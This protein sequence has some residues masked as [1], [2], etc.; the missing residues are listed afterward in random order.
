MRNSPGSVSR[1]IKL[2]RGGDSVA[3]TQVWNRYCKRLLAIAR[4]RLRGAGQT[5]SDEEDVVVD[6]FHSV[7]RRLHC[8]QYPKL[9]DRDGLWKLLA[10]ATTNKAITQLRFQNR[11]KRTPKFGWDDQ[12]GQL[13][14]VASR[15]DSAHDAVETADL[16]DHLLAVLPDD[17][18]RRI[19]LLRLNG[20]GVSEIG[21][22]VGRSAP[23]I[24]RRLRLIRDLWNK[25]LL[26]GHP[27][28]SK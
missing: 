18:C 28:K 17:Q 4:S 16:L 19:C 3:V 7:F 2:I 12:Q 24:E 21:Q 20:F 6:A 9:L 14:E 23:T 27:K 25:E 8:G 26:D 11:L 22:Q 10:T 13:E 5:M 1:L 15:V